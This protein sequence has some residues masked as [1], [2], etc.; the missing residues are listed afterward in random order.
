[1]DK[2]NAEGYYDPTAYNA[3]TKI[4]KDERKAAYKPLVYI[5]SPFRGDTKR[6]MFMAREYCRFAIKKN[7]IPFAP[8]LL[9]P[10]FM[11]DDEEK[12]RELAMFFNKVF[13]CK[14]DELWVFGNK[15]TEGMAHEITLAEK[16]RIKIIYFIEKMEVRDESNRNRI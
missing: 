16:R 2:R 13:L 5:C 11:N 3:L 14:C 10:Q 15:V 8:H 4:M 1:M 7:C 12:E 9:F 6:N